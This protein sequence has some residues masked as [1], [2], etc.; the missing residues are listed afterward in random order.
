MTFE[1]SNHIAAPEVC[2]GWNLGFEVRL[3]K[4]EGLTQSTR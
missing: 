4:A 2:L 1:P 3:L